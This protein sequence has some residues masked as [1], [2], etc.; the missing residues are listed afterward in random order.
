MYVFSVN[1]S[2][3]MYTVLVKTGH[4]VLVTGIDPVERC[5]AELSIITYMCS[6]H[7]CLQIIIVNELSFAYFLIFSPSLTSTNTALSSSAS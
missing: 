6:R 1:Y 3:T 4:F 2:S 7:P 5:C